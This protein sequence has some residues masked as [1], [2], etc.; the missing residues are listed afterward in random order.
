MSTQNTIKQL[1]KP[2][3]SSCNITLQWTEVLLLMFWPFQGPALGQNSIQTNSKFFS[4]YVQEENLYF[5]KSHSSNNTEMSH[6]EVNTTVVPSELQLS[7]CS[8]FPPDCGLQWGSRGHVSP[9]GFQG[10]CL[11]I[12]FFFYHS[13]YS[14]SVRFTWVIKKPEIKS[15]SNQCVQ[16]YL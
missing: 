2:I 15:Q 10:D 11:V 3:L 8:R 13:W 7:C 12:F 4:I 14:T 1:T 9:S 16:I 6:V 5:L